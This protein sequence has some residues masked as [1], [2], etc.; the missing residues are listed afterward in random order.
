MRSARVLAAWAILLSVLLSCNVLNPI[1]SSSTPPS[2]PSPNPSPTSSPNSTAS[3]TSGPPLLLNEILFHPVEAQPQFV[4][5]KNPGPATQAAGLALV[6]EAGQRLAL[7]DGFQLKAGAVLLVVFD[8]QNKVEGSTVHADR[9]SFLNPEAGA[10]QLIRANGT[11]LDQVAWGLSQSRAVRLSRGGVIADL[12]PGTTIGRFP[13]STRVDPLEW[14]TFAPEQATPGAVNPQPAVEILLPVNGAIFDKPNISLSWYPIAGA[15]QY[16]VQV[17]T[18]DTFAAPVADQ[19]VALPRLAPVGLAAGH[20]FWRVQALAS[21]G[22]AAAFSPVS[23]LTIRA[24]SPAAHLASPLMEKTLAVPYIQQHK[25]TAMLLLESYNDTGTHAWDVDHKVLDE[26]DPADNANCALAVTAMIAAYYGGQLSQDRI[27]YEIFKDVASGPE[28]DLNYGYGLT[29]NQITTAL[30]FALGA[31]PS[32][33]AVTT[34]A[35]LWTVVKDEIDAGRP[36]YTIILG[37]A[38]AVIGYAESAGTQFVTVNDPWYGAYAMDIT[39]LRAIHYWLMP[40]NVKPASD[41]PGIR[42]D[43]DGDGVVDF[44]ETERFHTD[45]NNQDT[46]TDK[47]PDKVEIHASVFDPKHGYAVCAYGGDS[48]DRNVSG[49]TTLPQPVNVGTDGCDGRDFDHDNVPMELDLDSDGGGCF[50]GMED[51]N[52]DGKYGQAQGETY[53]FDPKDD[54]CILGRIDDFTDISKADGTH[55][56]RTQISEF[57]LKPGAGGLLTGRLRV[58]HS[59]FE[60]VNVDKAGCALMRVT[61]DPKTAIWGS[62]LAG[63]FQK[64]SDGSLTISFRATSPDPAKSTVTSSGGCS[65]EVTSFPIMAITRFAGGGG[66]TM[67]KL[68]DGHFDHR[69]DNLPAGYSGSLYT[70]FHIVQSPNK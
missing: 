14:V 61:Y 34:A 66:E 30:S 21:D 41:E 53:N 62:D 3:P 22:S 37:H 42:Q 56:A 57:S 32:D 23:T 54:P 20:Y 46:D 33:H 49:L 47:I 10:V 40:H 24:P 69:V 59:E 29:D 1:S 35:D 31:A 44:D 65:G 15:V 51:T 11:I 17:A 50:D 64:N 16:R 45:P 25:D 70:L 38:L 58:T 7:P 12:A 52:F 68:V 19:T 9:A 55:A 43:S 60:D 63:T 27:G 5:I 39:H 18:E 48:R 4:E 36:V 67:F 13:L 28:R 8:S 2:K 26:N 6:N